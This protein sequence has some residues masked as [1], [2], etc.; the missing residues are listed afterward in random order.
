VTFQFLATSL[1]VLS[2]EGPL[3]AGELADSWRFWV[4]RFRR[5]DVRA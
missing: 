3:M 5:M 2:N 1:S 4:L